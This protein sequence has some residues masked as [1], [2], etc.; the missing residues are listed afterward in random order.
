MKTI[1]SVLALSLVVLEANAQTTST[2]ILEDYRTKAAPVQDKLNSTLH[3]QGTAVAAELVKKGDTAGAAT[4]SAQIDDKI[5]GRPVKAPHVSIT[6]LLTQYDAARDAA[7]KPLKTASIAKIE[8][9]LK[10][11][12]GK[13]MKAVVDLAK[14]R[15]EIETGK[16]ADALPPITIPTAWNYYMDAGRQKVFGELLLNPDGTAT[17]K[18][19]PGTNEVTA[20][21][22]EKTPKREVVNVWLAVAT[23]EEACVLRADGDEGV[24]ERA[25]GVR[26][27]KA[28]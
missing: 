10:T 4:V 25:I 7:L 11:S 20:G 9:V 27:L 12:A 2:Q 23:G 1:L 17:L 13:D 6:K 28:K 14:A 15:E 22:W 19:K 26:F 16:V 3:K 21:R 8:A 18:G 24:L 5:V